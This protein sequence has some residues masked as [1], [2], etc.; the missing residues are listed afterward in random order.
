[1]KTLRDSRRLRGKLLPT[2]MLCVAAAVMMTAA[3]YALNPGAPLPPPLKAGVKSVTILNLPSL[4]V[5]A[6][7]NSLDG[8]KAVKGRIVMPKASGRHGGLKAIAFPSISTLIRMGGGV[9]QVKAV[10]LKAVAV[11]PGRPASIKVKLTYV[12]GRS[13]PKAVVVELRTGGAPAASRGS[14]GI[15]ELSYLFISDSHVNHA[16]LPKGIKAYYVRKPIVVTVGGRPFVKGYKVVKGYYVRCGALIRYSRRFV[17]IARNSS[18]TVT[19][20]VSI[21]KYVTG[22]TYK[23]TLTG[24]KVVRVVGHAGM[25]VV[26][27]PYSIPVKVVTPKLFAPRGRW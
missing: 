15:V 20:Y 9:I 8:H 27:E 12:G 5:V 6:R 19:A 22:G 13:S 25:P 1:M 2:A 26:V 17:V 14:S 21:P 11:M 4:K 3:A 24:V 18:V 16:L 23:V 7:G 10:G